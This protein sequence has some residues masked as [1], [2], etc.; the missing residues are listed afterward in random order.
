MA[1]F[2]TGC[3]R[4]ITLAALASRCQTAGM[5]IST[6]TCVVVGILILASVVGGTGLWGV[7]LSQQGPLQAPA[8]VVIEPGQGPRRIAAALA[9]A[10]VI[11]HPAAFVA[12]VRVMGMDSTLKAGEYA[13]EPGISLRAVVNKL[14][15]GVVKPGGLFA[16]FSCTGLVAE[17]QFLDMLRRAAYFSGR[18]IQI[19]KVA[20]AGPDHP[21]MAHV[22]ESRYLKAVFCRVVD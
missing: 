10:G 9:S 18:T 5:K 14:A 1:G 15:L 19:L 12:A 8:S 6:G 21:F 11:D 22:Q 17:D 20:G 2:F 16:T 7:Y 4:G 13:F 3:G